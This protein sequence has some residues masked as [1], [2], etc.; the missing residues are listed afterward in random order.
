MDSIWPT[1][2]KYAPQTLKG[3]LYWPGGHKGPHT[4][5]HTKLGYVNS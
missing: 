3:F 4:G 1:E 5:D 2:L